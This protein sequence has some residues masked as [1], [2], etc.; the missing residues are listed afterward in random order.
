MP[1]P[2]TLYLYVAKCIVVVVGCLR[3]RDDA[4]CSLVSAGGKAAHV[5][6]RQAGHYW[7]QDRRRSCSLVSPTAEKAHS[8]RPGRLATKATHVATVLGP[9]GRHVPVHVVP[10]L[11]E[12][13]V[14]MYVLCYT[15]VYSQLIPGSPDTRR[16]RRCVMDEPGPRLRR[17]SLLGVSLLQI[18]FPAWAVY[19]PAGC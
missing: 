7:G 3:A 17:P 6:P 18:I 9:G 4:A 13:V 11:P 19:D 15:Y 14:C 12:A 8:G 5:T 2:S 16:R 10:C 1:H